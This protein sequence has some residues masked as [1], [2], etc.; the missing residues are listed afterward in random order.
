MAWKSQDYVNAYQQQRQIQEQKRIADEM[1]KQNV[2]MQQQVA[3][4]QRQ[5]DMMQ[6]QQQEQRTA[7]EIE[8]TIDRLVDKEEAPAKLNA[9]I[10]A[11]DDVITKTPESGGET[12]LALPDALSEAPAYVSTIVSL[13]ADIESKARAME[14]VSIA[15]I[16]RHK[17]DDL[18][19]NASVASALLGLVEALRTFQG[20]LSEHPL[21]DI[22]TPRTR[23]TEYI[24]GTGAD[25]SREELTA[26]IALV[27]EYSATAQKFLEKSDCYKADRVPPVV[28]AMRKTAS[29]ITA[30]VNSFWKGQPESDH[31]RVIEHSLA[32]G[33]YLTSSH[34]ALETA[35]QTL[36]EFNSR[37]DEKHP[38]DVR[39][40]P[41]PITAAR[42]KIEEIV[43]GLEERTKNTSTWPQAT[44]FANNLKYV[45]QYR[46]VAQEVLKAYDALPKNTY[47][48]LAIFSLT[49]GIMSF[50]GVFVTGI[51]AIIAGHMALNRLKWHR[52]RGLAIAGLILG[53]VMTAIGI[54]WVVDTHRNKESVPVPSVQVAEQSVPTPA[55]EDVTSSPGV[56][57]K[58]KGEDV[59]EVN[60]RRQE[61]L[62]RHHG[63]MAAYASQRFATVGFEP[64]VLVS[65]R[66]KALNCT[67][68]FLGKNLAD[69]KQAAT[70]KNWVRVMTL[71]NVADGYRD[72]SSVDE[73]LRRL[74]E[75]E[76]YLLVKG[77][78]IPNKMLSCLL[79]PSVD[80]SD[81]EPN[82]YQ[83]SRPTTW[84][85]HPDGDGLMHKWRAIDREVLLLVSQ[86][87]FN[88]KR[89]DWDKN[90]ERMVEDIESQFF[91]ATAALNKKME[92]GD[93]DRPAF[94]TRMRELRSKKRDAY[95]ALV[96]RF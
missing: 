70:D 34:D 92:L 43:K 21:N 7:Q 87:E 14:I 96:E 27:K 88:S 50:G 94:A 67:I 36:A 90:V 40:I 13:L 11:V 20:F 23:I 57:S 66:A 46:E 44:C 61:A 39:Q 71:L 9:I 24:D 10:Q 3:A 6:R 45:N 78:S 52:G 83:E 65:P 47:S 82:W 1:A 62:V 49:L 38:V 4:V 59:N 25:K 16:V 64:K 22:N 95:L 69:F 55:T 30:A 63:D 93:L 51:P 79:I 26:A 73:A 84:E 74:K 37:H 72:K 18:E 68:T 41:A 76:F 12:A 75:Q 15:S 33:D 91:D 54:F 53:Y 60:T 8:Y 42:S 35:C 77:D 48:G 81:A 85:V 19:R 2:A 89:D 80:D 32:L 28:R 17:L 86:T 56:P 5:M 31:L 29:E 58:A